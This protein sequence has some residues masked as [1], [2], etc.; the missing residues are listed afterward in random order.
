MT[1]LNQL[2][3]SQPALYELDF[4]WTGFQWI[5]LH[6]SQQSTLSYFR[7]AKDGSD[8]VVCVCNFT[9]VPRMEY[10]LGVPMGGAYQELLNSDAEIYGGS[11]MGNAGKVLAEE[12]PWH[13]Q[14]YSLLITLPPLATVFFKPQ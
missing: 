4:D 11:N 5:D 14:P 12:I 9:P 10:R 8:I 2:Y 13:G 6:D 3:L 1:D 7:K